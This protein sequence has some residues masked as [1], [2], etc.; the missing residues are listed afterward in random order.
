[1]DVGSWAPGVL[2][3][4]FIVLLMCVLAKVP[5]GLSRRGQ[6]LLLALAGVVL[7]SIGSLL[8]G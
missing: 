3:V 4:I 8:R 1:M 6:A 7:F 2:L 5:R